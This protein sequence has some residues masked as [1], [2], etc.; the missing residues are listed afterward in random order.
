MNKD[1]ENQ[2]LF[3]KVTAISNTCKETELLKKGIVSER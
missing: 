2:T 3:Y 1:M